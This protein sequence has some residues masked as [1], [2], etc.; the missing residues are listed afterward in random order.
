[1]IGQWEAA[2]RFLCKETKDFLRLREP[3]MERM[4]LSIIIVRTCILIMNKYI[5]ELI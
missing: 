2:F 4:Q 3:E 1:S 5:S